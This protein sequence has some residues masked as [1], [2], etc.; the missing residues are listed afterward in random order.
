MQKI[1]ENFEEIRV[2]E[3]IEKKLIKAEKQINEGKTI[4]SSK[5]FKEL[6]EQFKL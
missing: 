5:V 3:F 2:N 6:E 4:K 1:N